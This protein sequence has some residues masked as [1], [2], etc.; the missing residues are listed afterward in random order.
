MRLQSGEDES[1]AEEEDQ[2]QLQSIETRLLQYDPTFTESDTMQ[3]Q[4]HAKNAL[5]NS[6][7]RGGSDGKY[8][9]EDLRQSHQLHLN[10]ERIR[11]PE[12]WFQPSMF[13]LDCAGMGEV[14]G[15]LLN[16]FEEDQR[17][18]MMQV[19]GRTWSAAS[20]CSPPRPCFH[21]SMP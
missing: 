13:A 21:R 4:A 11:V 15:W 6:F 16:G 1:D 8:E 17:K 9:P 2:T 20:S 5:I 10:V 18:R 14:A 12:A 3:G 19:S 7:V